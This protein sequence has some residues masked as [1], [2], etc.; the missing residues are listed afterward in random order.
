[1]RILYSKIPVV[2]G[3]NVEGKKVRGSVEQVYEWEH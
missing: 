3:V 1:M 2:E